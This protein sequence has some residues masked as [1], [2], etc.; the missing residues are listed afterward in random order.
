[1]ASSTLWIDKVEKGYA[2]F[3]LPMLI[4]PILLSYHI[5]NVILSNESW[6][7][8]VMNFMHVIVSI[9]PDFSVRLDIQI[10]MLK[11]R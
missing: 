9:H 1:M 8:K 2:L 3:P 5:R 11:P 6:V 4:Q 10:A 7:S